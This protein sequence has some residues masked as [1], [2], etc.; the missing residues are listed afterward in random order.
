MTLMMIITNT[1]LYVWAIFIYL[2]TM[3]YIATKTRTIW[4]PKLFIIPLVLTLLKW[5]KIMSVSA[6]WTIAPW[7]LGLNLGITKALMHKKV[8]YL[9]SKNSI[10]LPGSYATLFMF[11]I[12]FVAKYSLGFLQSVNPAMSTTY[13]NM[14]TF[15]TFLFAGYSLGKAGAYTSGFLKAKYRK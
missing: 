13:A 14:D 3:G 10:H 9:I 12:L 15:I 8:E 1:P 2:M 6:L 4:V 7:L 11:L 5:Q